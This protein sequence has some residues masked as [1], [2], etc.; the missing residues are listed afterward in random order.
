VSYNDKYMTRWPSGLRRNVKA[1]VF[2]GVGSN[3][4][5]VTFAGKD[6][7]VFRYLFFIKNDCLE[8]KESFNGLFGLM[9]STVDGAPHCYNQNVRKKERTIMSVYH[10][11]NC[12]KSHTH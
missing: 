3:P 6:Q 9:C 11:I 12:H 1:V 2:I 7:Y 5:R 10:R 8:E 4:T